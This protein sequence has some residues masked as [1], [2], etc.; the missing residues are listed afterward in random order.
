M[1]AFD[2]LKK[3]GFQG[4]VVFFTGHAR[5]YLQDALDHG[6]GAE[7]LEKPV[8]VDKLISVVLRAM[9]ETP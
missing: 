1:D 9:N 8:D 5:I 4:K 2:W 3:Q 7:I 6:K